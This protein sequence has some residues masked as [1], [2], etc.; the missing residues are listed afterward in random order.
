MR[1]LEVQELSKIRAHVYLNIL[2]Y[3]SNAVVLNF[4]LCKLMAHI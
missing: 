2:R 1:I 4:H 3:E